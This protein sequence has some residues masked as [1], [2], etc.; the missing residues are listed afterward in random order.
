MHR[1]LRLLSAPASTTT[2]LAASPGGAP[3]TAHLPLRGKNL[4]VL[5]DDAHC[6]RMAAL[7]GVAAALGL[8]VT[9]IAPS[10]ARLL[11]PS[12]RLPTAALLGRLY[13]AIECH[14]LPDDVINCLRRVSD[15]PVWAH[16][17]APPQ[18][19]GGG[20]DVGDDA[21]GVLRNW[22]LRAIV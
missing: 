4:A 7:E 3:A 21:P 13:D 10:T 15:R 1:P 14:G 18:A 22:L 8:T 9:H 11:D 6:A 17:E 19:P 16:R 5:C 2:P 20:G 12:R